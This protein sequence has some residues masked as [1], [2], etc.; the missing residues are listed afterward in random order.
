[1]SKSKES[2]NKTTSHG[3]KDTRIQKPALTSESCQVVKN[4]FLKHTIRK[5]TISGKKSPDL[6]GKE[7]DST[8]IADLD[9]SILI[10]K[11]RENEAY[12]EEIEKSILDNIESTRTIINRNSDLMRCSEDRPLSIRPTEVKAQEESSPIREKRRE[13]QVPES[14]WSKQQL[15]KKPAQSKSKLNYHKVKQKQKNCLVQKPADHNELVIKPERDLLDSDSKMSPAPR[16]VITANSVYLQIS[17]QIIRYQ[18]IHLQPIQ[19]L[20][21]F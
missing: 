18:F 7:Q 1:M 14:E 12:L 9:T 3:V 4:P 19:I 15:V 2:C 8:F 10:K 11:R 17:P 6:M 21:Y 16:V 5:E 20:V 13:S